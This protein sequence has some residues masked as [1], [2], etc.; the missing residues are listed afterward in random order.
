MEEPLFMFQLIIAVDVS[1]HRSIYN[2]LNAPCS[3]DFKQLE[4]WSCV[5]SI[6]SQTVVFIKQMINIQD[7]ATLNPSWTLYFMCVRFPTV[8]ELFYW[9]SLHIVV[10][11]T[12]Y[13]PFECLLNNAY[14]CPDLWHVVALCL[15]LMINISD[16]FNYAYI[17]FINS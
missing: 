2:K 15:L 8:S 6:L 1:E 17:K 11:P 7:G 10:V 9:S 14:F 12:A 4:S 3:G 13:S 16:T 5:F